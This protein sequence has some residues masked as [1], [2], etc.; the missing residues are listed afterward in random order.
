MVIRWQAWVVW[1]DF[2]VVGWVVFFS[3]IWENRKTS[4]ICWD[5]LCFLLNSESPHLLYSPHGVEPHLPSVLG[6]PYLPAASSCCFQIIGEEV[7]RK[8]WSYPGLMRSKSDT[9]CS[10]SRF[11]LYTVLLGGFSAS[12]L[13]W[14]QGWRAESLVFSSA[15]P[16]LI[17]HNA[18]HTPLFL[19]LSLNVSE[20]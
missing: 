9:S 10:V 5:V 1:H 14:E 12:G 20:P 11:S 8:S 7:R 15:L 13:K 18:S 6:T 4:L 3:V 16:S 19:F 17:Y 2:D